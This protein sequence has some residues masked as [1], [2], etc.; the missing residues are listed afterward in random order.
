MIKQNNIIYAAVHNYSNFSPNVLPVC[1]MITCS[2][3]QTNL[4]ETYSTFKYMNLYIHKCQQLKQGYLDIHNWPLWGNYE[5][6]KG[7]TDLLVPTFLVALNLVHF[8][9]LHSLYFSA[10]LWAFSF[11][12]S[13]TRCSLTVECCFVRNKLCQI[14]AKQ[15]ASSRPNS[16]H[17]NILFHR[18]T[19]SSSSNL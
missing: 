1:N 18:R 6:R 16:T 11:K 14:S 8:L 19:C 5:T 17:L 10:L 3:I 4:N 7:C 9:L 2:S 15:T 13:K 12:V